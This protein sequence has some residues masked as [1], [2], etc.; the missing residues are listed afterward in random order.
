MNTAT[1]SVKGQIVIPKHLRQAAQVSFGDEF[2]I[3]F[4]NGEIRLR[5]LSD[6]KH[7]ALDQVAGCMA[8]PE[9]AVTTDAAIEQAIKARLKAK[10]A[11]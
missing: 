5:P 7:S 2:A 4:S 9:R 3:S 1:L 10:F 6:K 8:R 11:A